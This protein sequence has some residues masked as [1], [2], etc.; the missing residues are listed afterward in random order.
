MRPASDNRK[1]AFSG[2]HKT[3]HR[4][5]PT[6]ASKTVMP[7][8]G[9]RSAITE[10]N[11]L[12]WLLAC[13]GA[14]LALRLA[15][16]YAAKID[17][18]LDEAQY[19]TWSRELAFG[20][21]SK[22]PMIAWVIRG[23]SEICGDSE[24]CIRSASPVLYTV[25]AFML[26]LTG[27]ALYGPRVGFWS[28][29]VFAT[30]P[31]VSFSSN[32]ITTDVPLILFWTIA[33]YAWVMLVKRQSMR[34][35]V[36]LG[37]A[38]GLGLLAKQAMLYFFLCIAC[39]AAM[40]RDAREVLKAG[41]AIVVVLIAAALFSP[42]LIWNAYHGFSTVK[43]T[44]A[45]I[46][47]QYPYIHPL[48]LLEYLVVQFGVFGPILVVVLVRSAW[49]EIRRP[50]DDGK[51]LFL[52]FSLPVLALLAVQ[53]LLSRALG[54]WSA[55]AYP[56]A[57]ILVTQVLLELNRRLLFR[58]SLALHLAIAA[59]FAAAP[60]FATQWRLF[61]QLQFLRVVSGWHA[62]ADGVRIKLA[63]DRYG[64]ILVD[65]REMAANLLYYLRDIPTPLNVWPSGRSPRNHYEM[66]RP[67]TASAPEP[68]LFVSLKVCPGNL[69]T[70]FGTA[71]KLGPA[72]IPIVRDRQRVL[73][74]CRLAGFKRG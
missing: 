31:G 53:A 11:Y 71:T 52:S 63:E 18:G 69:G 32:L 60:A 30:L 23:T 19:W 7:R 66:T 64:S 56:A 3:L 49:R 62:V 38:I 21:F 48:R 55:T 28:A 58:I 65:S 4:G 6:H 33:L 2:T 45:N 39:H 37:V 29:L 40:S 24:A 67:F 57:S 9:Q 12:L 44:G 70:A 14:L 20:Y 22:P 10:T 5:R 25:A 59:T 1:P 46:G 15:G 50:S 61:E 51:I 27:R 34:F 42:N 41:R 72:S 16:I 35:A 68:I 47:W 36:L 43:H 54:N 74:F 13:L 8:Q 73:Y 17:L 26:Y